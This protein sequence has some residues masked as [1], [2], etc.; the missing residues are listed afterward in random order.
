MYRRLAITLALGLTFFAGIPAQAGGG[1]H[2]GPYL[3]PEQPIYDTTRA[4]GRPG[5]RTAKG[6]EL[7][8]SHS[9][10]IHRFAHFF[11]FTKDQAQSK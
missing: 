11:G 1:S 8:S 3:V 6:N 4:S 2:P 10:A 5:D 9:S 7:T